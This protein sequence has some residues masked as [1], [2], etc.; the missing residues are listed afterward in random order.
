M[1]EYY[2]K[3]AFAEDYPRPSAWATPHDAFQAALPRPGRARGRSAFVDEGLLVSNARSAF[4]LVGRALG[5]GPGDRVLLPA[6]HCRSMVEPF[7][8]LGCDVDFYRVRSDLSADAVH[9]A[10]LWSDRTR[11]VVAVDYFGFV[12]DNAVLIELARERGATLVRD[13]AHRLLMPEL[14]GGFDVAIA[15]LPK[16]LPV[17]EGGSVVTRL[18]LGDLTLSKGPQGRFFRHLRRI[19]STSLA[20]RRERSAF[21]MPAT[22][23]ED[24]GAVASTPDRTARVNGQGPEYEYFDPSRYDVRGSALVGVVARGIDLDDLTERRRRH[25]RRLHEAAARNP[26]I[27]PLFHELPQGIAPYVYPVVLSEPERQFEL[28]RRNGIAIQR[29]EDLAVTDCR[30]SAA[31]RT[32]LVQVP[33]HQDLSPQQ[34]EFIR[35]VIGLL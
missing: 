34:V 13:C 19:A 5:V 20:K 28:L 7:R 6:F 21:R 23:I 11:V 2:P 29:W 18:P 27:T 26:T 30:I 3:L 4:A 35:S 8:W 32:A 25:Y 16:F 24:P 12:Q 9:A 33:C 15:S 10:S 1:V 14:D 31:Y 22:L 17:P